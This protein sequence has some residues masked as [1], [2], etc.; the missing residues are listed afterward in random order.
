MPRKPKNAAPKTGPED[1]SQKN[2]LTVRVAESA[3]SEERA[4]TPEDIEAVFKG[5]NRMHFEGLGDAWGVLTGQNPAA[6]MPQI[7][8]TVLHA[9]GTRPPWQWKRRGREYVVMAWPQDQPVRAAVLLAGDEGDKLR[10]VTVVP[11]LEGLPNDLTVEEV[12]PWESGDGANVA[13]NMI[14]GENP[15]WFYDPLYRRDCDDLTPGVTHT[16]LLAGLA[17]GMR[18][19]LLDELTITDGPRYEAHARAW[20]AENPEKKRL[21]VPPLKVRVAGRHIIMPGRNFCEYQMRALVE[22]VQDVQLENIPVK[23]VYLRFP[24]EGREDVRLPVYASKTVLG[25]FVPEAGKEVDAYV[26]LQGRI[27][28]FEEDANAQ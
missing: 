7:T 15:M 14:D 16:F 22:E 2:R 26:W 28:D 1:D 27:I 24:F 19:A 12:H 4:L 18:K 3:A 13:V 6:V 5:K 21:D 25:D 9:G 20:L 10:P 17:Y 11:L 8:G 23:L